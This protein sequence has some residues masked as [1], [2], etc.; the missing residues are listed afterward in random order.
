VHGNVEI[1]LVADDLITSEEIWDPEEGKSITVVRFLG[2]EVGRYSIDE[3]GVPEALQE[4]ALERRTEK[5][6]RK[7]RALD[8]DQGV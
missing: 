4:P 7:L 2:A 3:F 6:V 1:H 8:D 5:L